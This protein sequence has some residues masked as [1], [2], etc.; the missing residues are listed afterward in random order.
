LR[1]WLASIRQIV[2]TVYDKL[3]NTFSASIGSDLTI[4][5]RLAGAAGSESGAAQLLYV[6]Q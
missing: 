3:F 2:E 1:R 6:A 4:F 5:G